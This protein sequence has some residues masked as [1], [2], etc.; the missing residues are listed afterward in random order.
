MAFFGNKIE[1]G[2]DDEEAIGSGSIEKA[3]PRLGGF[4]ASVGSLPTGAEAV[5]TAVGVFRTTSVATEDVVAQLRVFDSGAT[6]PDGGGA[7]TTL[8][9]TSDVQTIPGGGAVVGDLAP[10][11]FTFTGV[12][13][14]AG[15]DVLLC[16][17]AVATSAAIRLGGQLPSAPGVDRGL[18]GTGVYTDATFVAGTAYATNVAGWVNYSVAGDPLNNS[19]FVGTFVV[20]ADLVEAMIA[21]SGNRRNTLFEYLAPYGQTTS[22][23]PLTKAQMAQTYIIPDL[24]AVN[25]IKVK[26]GI[27]SH[28]FL[29]VMAWG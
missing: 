12:T 22:T 1:S 25:S 23:P 15:V 18:T 16:F 2:W 13:L 6:S 5:S 20:D 28:Q 14:T 19:D 7:P 4:L 26:G 17:G 27:R 8:I 21:T 9:A 29:T 10:L 11:T 3:T 24:D